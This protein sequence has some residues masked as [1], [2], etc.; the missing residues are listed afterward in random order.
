MNDGSSDLA[1]KLKQAVE[2]F[3]ASRNPN[4]GGIVQVVFPI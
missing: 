4:G 3:T 1:S 2:A